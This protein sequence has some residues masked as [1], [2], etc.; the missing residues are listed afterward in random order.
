MKDEWRCALITSGEL[1]ATALGTVE[2]PQLCASSLVILPQEVSV[3]H[4]RI[5]YGSY[6]YRS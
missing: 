1:Y 3:Y 4:V 6:C 5:L 2:M